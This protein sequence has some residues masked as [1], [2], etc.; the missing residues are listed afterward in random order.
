MRGHPRTRKIAENPQARENRKKYGNNAENEGEALKKAYQ[1]T[2]R[3]RRKGARHAS[4]KHE[5]LHEE[6]KA[7]EVIP[8]GEGKGWKRPSPAGS[9]PCGASLIIAAERIKD[10]QQ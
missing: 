8:V 3:T 5:E 9:D 2:R 4:N 1:R 10:V 6:G 7:R